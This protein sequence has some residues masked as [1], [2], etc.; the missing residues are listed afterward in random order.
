[1]DHDGAVVD[2]ISLTQRSPHHEHGKEVGGSCGDGRNRVFD[3]VEQRVCQHQIVDRVAREAELGE[4]GNGHSVGIQCAGLLDDRGGVGCRI[5]EH[6]RGGERRNPGKPVPVAIAEVCRRR[7]G[8]E[9][10]LPQGAD[11]GGLR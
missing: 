4:H 5:R 11:N 1:M 8:H 3:G 7:R 10:S 9:R 2:P 6:D